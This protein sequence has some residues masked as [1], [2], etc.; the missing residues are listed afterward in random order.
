MPVLTNS[1]P[2]TFED[3][4]TASCHVRFYRAIAAE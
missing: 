1:A 3:M 4:E 2:Y